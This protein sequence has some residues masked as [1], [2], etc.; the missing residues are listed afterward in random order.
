MFEIWFYLIKHCWGIGY[1]GMWRGR[2]CGEGLLTQ[3]ME[4][5]LGGVGGGG[6]FGV[7]TVLKGLMEF[8]FGRAQGKG[9][10]SS[11]VVLVLR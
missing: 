2:H 11:V 4:V 7:P 10:R 1:G 5:Y 9:G 8:V 6:L 3:S